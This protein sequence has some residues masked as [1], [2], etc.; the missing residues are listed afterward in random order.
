MVFTYLNSVRN[1][2]SI[3]KFTHDNFSYIEFDLF[4]FSIKDLR[5]KTM[6]FR[7]NS[8]GDLYTTPPPTKANKVFAL[9]ILVRMPP[10]LYSACRPV[11][12]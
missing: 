9:A 7:C 12:I 6:I 10:L 2:L 4:G 11:A 5:T 1:L 8:S 3:H